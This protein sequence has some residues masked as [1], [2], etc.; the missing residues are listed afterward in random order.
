MATQRRYRLLVNT[1]DKFLNAIALLAISITLLLLL[2]RAIPTP[3]EL[4]SP[5]RDD[6]MLGQRFDL[7]GDL[8]VVEGSSPSRIGV[9]VYIFSTT[10]SWCEAQKERVPQLLGSLPGIA[11]VT[12]SAEPDSL[13][14]DY[15]SGTTGS[16]GRPLSLRPEVAKRFVP[17]LTPRL[18]LIDNS[19]V[20]RDAFLGTF[21]RWSPEEFAE[22]VSRAFA[23]ATTDS[24]GQAVVGRDSSSPM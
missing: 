18:L 23:D 11:I 12:A 20:V 6:R 21:A 4:P 15:W 10:C 14:E 5:Q 17:F 1:L 19:G 9:V 13:V 2:K 24:T 8:G 7:A 16:L 22:R 3:P